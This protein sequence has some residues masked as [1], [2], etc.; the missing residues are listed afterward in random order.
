MPKVVINN[1]GNKSFGQL[2]RKLSLHSRGVW[3]NLGGRRRE[4]EVVCGDGEGRD[5]CSPCS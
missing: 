5:F 3:F 1:F 4:G 2:K